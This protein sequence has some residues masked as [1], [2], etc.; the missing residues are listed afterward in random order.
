MKRSMAA[1]QA[2]ARARR[3]SRCR[4]GGFTTHASAFCTCDASRSTSKKRSTKAKRST[5]SS[6]HGSFVRLERSGRFQAARSSGSTT[7]STKRTFA[8]TTRLSSTLFC[9]T[10]SRTSPSGNTPASTRV[11]GRP[12]ARFPRSLERPRTLAAKATSGCFVGGVPGLIRRTNTLL[13]QVKNV[14]I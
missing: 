10:N 4:C 6:G 3:F 14:G 9:S 13:Y 1:R 8:T 7:A 5:P 12:I 2:E 11:C